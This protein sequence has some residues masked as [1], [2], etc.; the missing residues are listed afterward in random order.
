MVTFDLQSSDSRDISRKHCDIPMYE[1]EVLRRGSVDIPADGGQREED[2]IVPKRLH[3]KST[4]TNDQLMSLNSIGL[5]RGM[6]RPASKIPCESF[7]QIARLCGDVDN[8][9]TTPRS[10][11]H[12]DDDD[13]NID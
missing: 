1:S 9:P 5:F 3:S 6:Q 8:E 2:T 11:V 12:L 13:A 10:G 7:S 4:N